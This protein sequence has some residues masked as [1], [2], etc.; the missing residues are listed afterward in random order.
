MRSRGAQE[1]ARALK[2]LEMA[3]TGGLKE[4]LGPGAKGKPGWLTIWLSVVC[5]SAVADVDVHCRVR[6]VYGYC[7]YRDAFCRVAFRARTNTEARWNLHI[8]GMEE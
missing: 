4:S 6:D 1:E 3:V 8:T 5:C 2:Q 7:C